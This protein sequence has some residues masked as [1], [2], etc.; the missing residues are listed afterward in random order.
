M[1]ATTQNSLGIKLFLSAL[2]ADNA[3]PLNMKRI[4]LPLGASLLLLSQPA[5]AQ[6][7]GTWNVNSSGSWST[8]T[9]WTS[10]PDVPGEDGSIVSLT[11]DITN[12]RTVTIDTTS[13][14]V[15]QL[16]IGDPNGS[17]RYNIAASGGAG[18]IFQNS[19]NTAELV[20]TAN[21]A[22][23]GAI[24]APFSL[25]DSLEISNNS[26]NAQTIS[27]TISSSTL[28]L[29]TIEFAESGSGL[30]TLSGAITDGSFG[31][32]QIN[33]NNS[34]GGVILS[35][36]SNTF[37][38][39]LNLQ[40]G[41]LVLGL[42]LATGAGVLN[43]TG[44]SIESNGG[45]TRRIEGD[46]TLNG[47]VILGNSVNTG[48][49]VFDD[50]ASTLDLLSDSVINTVST[51]RIDHVITGAAGFTKTGASSLS[52]LNSA[53]TYTG[54]TNV[55]AGTLLIGTGANINSSSQVLV[56]DGAQLTNDSGTNFTTDL[57]L[58]D[59]AILAGT[60]TF[61][62][63]SIALVADLTGGAPSFSSISA[64]ATSLVK[65]GN[66]EF[67]LSNTTLGDYTI[68]SGSAISGSFTSI[69]VG[70]VG[71]DDLGSGNF[72]GTIGGFEYTFTNATN[73]F[74]VI[75]EPSTWSLLGIGVLFALVAR[76]RADSHRG[77]IAG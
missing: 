34:S 57:V 24:S 45:N 7:N 38:G 50:T 59:G 23:G 51:A 37:S 62:P 76:R 60:G 29:K 53:H 6:V 42:S 73:S 61:A 46:A 19:G 8:A 43:I 69:T 40:A 41:R 31:Q 63:I 66:M 56:S 21:A 47:T 13:R 75:P 20:Y 54:E 12:H 70:G 1:N 65:S 22:A 10:D 77:A 30:V 39:P 26:A 2:F 64:G 18:L 4:L 48:T 17:H 9:N 49:V 5:L 27:S 3:T 36:A 28:G 68:F 15:G 16:T 72:G 11:F 55:S 14:T 33:I 74:S 71:L 52:L 44:G 35:N 32:V 67:T 25:A 58:E